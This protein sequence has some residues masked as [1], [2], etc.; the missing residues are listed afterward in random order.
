VCGKHKILTLALILAV[1][2]AVV[3]GLAG[4]AEEPDATPLKPDRP[5][6]LHLVELTEVIEATLS[7]TSIYTGSLRSR[8]VVRIFNQEE[9]RVTELP[10]YEGDAVATGQVV[11]RLEDTLLQAELDIAVAKRR[12]AAANLSRARRL[13]Q[14]R[15]ISDDEVSHTNTALE[16]AAAEETVLRTRLGFA[17]V[18]APFDAVISARLVEVGDIVPRHTHVLT[19]ID[20]TAL[21]TDLPV[22]ELLI[23]HLAVND[24]VQV[25]IDAL[26]DR[27]FAGRV[28]RI[29]PQLDPRTRQGRVEVE[30]RPVPSGAQ[31]GQFTRVTFSTRALNRKVIPFRALRR[32]RDGEF[33]LR[34]T[35]HNLVERVPVRGGRRLG[36]RVEILEGLETGDR[37]VTKGFL[38]LKNGMEVTPVGAPAHLANGGGGD[39]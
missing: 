2:T 32:D 38:G 16:V 39:G 18:Q 28:L 1:T 19:L 27:K 21:V 34:L 11:L 30:L 8:R 29:H 7:A 23:P 15:L 14:K 17:T 31:A 13:Q 9:G 10:F 26:G 12:E 33:A 25:R 20:P 4:C 37:V 36:D 5:E 24:P 35:A 3:A 22:S 6:R